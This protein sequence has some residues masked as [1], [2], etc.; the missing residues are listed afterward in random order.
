MRYYHDTMLPE[1]AFQ[2]VGKRMTLEGGGKGSAPAAPN[3]AAAAEATA[4]SNQE[5]MSRQTWANRPTINTPWGQQTWEAAS[6]TDPATGLPVTNWTSNINLTPEQQQAL[7][8][9]QD[10]QKG[11]SEAAQT[12]LGQATKSFQKPFDWGG[13]PPQQSLED[14]GYDPTRARDRAEKALYEREVDKMEP[15][16]AQ[17][18]DA[19][20]ARLANMGISLEGGSEAF[21][22]AQTGMDDA[23]T[24]AYQDAARQAIIGGGAEASRELGMATGAAGFGNTLRQQ[25]IAEEAQR[26]GMTLNELNALLTG[27][28]VGMPGMPDFKGAGNA[29]GTDY[30]AAANMQGKYGLDAA[31]MDQESGMDWG[32]LLGTGAKAASLFA[33]SDRRLK[34]NIEP[35]GNGW[36][37]FSYLWE[38]V[39][40]VGVMAQEVLQ[41]NPEAV[42]VHPSGFL[43]VDYSK[44]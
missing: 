14:V 16:L 32:T 41:T 28:Q 23:R 27:Q 21:T 22:R 39:L 37:S 7:N 9:Q 15:M 24:G 38:N 34:K 11:R 18:E 13:M 5:A 36:Y 26:R 19:R 3:Y 35:V 42:A 44:I 4:A 17:S 2:P 20:R 8:A 25:A 31:R 10:I 43:M 33:M 40:R 12:L 1:L 29:G 30:L 6:A